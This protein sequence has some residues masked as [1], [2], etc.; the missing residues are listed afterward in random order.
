MY[1]F[2]TWNCLI[3]SQTT[4]FKLFKLKQFA[5]DNFKFDENHRKFSKR[6]ENI[7]GK[8]EIACN[9]QFLLFP[10][11]SKGLLPRGGKKCHCVEMG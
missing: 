6:V 9:K 4:D 1:N 11:F 2:Q 10:V 3:L 5:D 7:M 8:G